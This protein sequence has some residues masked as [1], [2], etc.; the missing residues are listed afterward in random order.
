MS[1]EIFTVRC[2]RCGAQIER[3]NPPEGETLPGSPLR[4]CPECGRL[5]FDNAYAEPALT[6][7]EE[8]EVN[9]PWIKILYALVPTLGA[10]VYLRQHLLTPTTGTLV[11]LIA[12]SIIAVFFDVL[13]I[14]ELIRTVPKL[15]RR[16]AALE[17]LEGRGGETDEALR[18]SMERLSKKDYLDA[19]VKCNAYVPTYFYKRIGEKPPKSF[20]RKEK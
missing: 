10:I 16:A 15:K 14:L 7:Y 13:L 1:E 4:K 11:P 3:E 9:F 6:A 5:Y 19:L 8:A 17:R 12:F 20:R 2:P 18:E